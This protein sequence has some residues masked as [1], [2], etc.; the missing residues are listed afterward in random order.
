VL[1]KINETVRDF[2]TNFK[3]SRKKI[4]KVVNNDDKTPN[5]NTVENTNTTSTNTVK[6]TIKEAPIVEQNETK[7]K[8]LQFRVNIENIYLKADPYWVNNV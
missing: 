2:S 8:S 1:K 4:K 5:N 7:L 3:N 6:N